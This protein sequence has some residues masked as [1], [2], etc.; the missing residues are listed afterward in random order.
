MRMM[1]SLPLGW[2]M[3]SQRLC[4]SKTKSKDWFPQTQVESMNVT[5]GLGKFVQEPAGLS[6]A[7]SE[8][9]VLVTCTEMELQ[10]EYGNIF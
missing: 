7:P 8:V 5:E 4:E 6:C 1:R 10:L 2:E 9:W 3:E